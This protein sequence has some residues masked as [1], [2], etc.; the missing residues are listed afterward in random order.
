MNTKRIISAIAAF[1]LAA[2][3]FVLAGCAGDSDAQDLKGEWKV[4]GTEVTFVFTGDKLKSLAGELEYTLDTGKKTISYKQDGQ[5]YSSASYS[6]SEDRK[7]L[8][9][10][11][12]YEDGGQRQTIFEKV[13]DNPDAE[14]S[15]GSTKSSSK[16]KS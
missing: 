15:A 1:C 3:L 10:D 6:F 5:E 9:L 11:E 2:S 13:S 12:H 7:T 16:K 14:P 4:Q 8:T